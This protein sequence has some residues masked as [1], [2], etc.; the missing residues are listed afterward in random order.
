MSGDFLMVGNEM[1]VSIH[2]TLKNKGGEV[3]DTSSGSEP[4]MY[5]H[6]HSQIVPGLENALTGKVKG[7]KLS[8]VVAPKDGYGDR[9]EDLVI[10]MPKG[11]GKLPDG[12]GIGDM[13][14]LQ[15]QDGFRVPARILEIKEDVIIVD[16]NHP[17]AG[18]DLY[19]DIELTDVRVATQQEL[20]HGHAHDGGIDH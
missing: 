7:D 10:T 3:V 15:S 8:V 6:G 19:F 11:N 9:R 20:D 4:L 1:V 14:E 13:L 2:Y 5:L 18:E 17:L 16:A 12:V